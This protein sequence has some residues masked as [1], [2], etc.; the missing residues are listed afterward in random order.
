MS[1]LDADVN[2]N[3]STFI[4][5]VSSSGIVQD[6]GIGLEDILGPRTISASIN[7]Q[8]RSTELILMVSVDVP[9]L[10]I[11]IFPLIVSPGFPL[12][13]SLSTVI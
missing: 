9:R 1:D 4:P 10:V 8:S 5:A 11:M 3:S 2:L 12:S 7:P 6:Q 13:L